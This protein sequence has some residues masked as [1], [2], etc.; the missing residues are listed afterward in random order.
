MISLIGL[1]A[2]A[3]LCYIV[4]TLGKEK[5]FGLWGTIAIS[6]VFT[7][8]VGLLVVLASDKKPAVVTTAS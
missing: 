7:P 3:A 4:G 1:I 2:Y 8:I 6:F 5:T